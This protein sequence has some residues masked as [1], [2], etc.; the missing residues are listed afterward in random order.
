MKAAFVSTQ[1][2]STKA[3]ALS[4]ACLTDGT[5]LKMSHHWL[6]WSCGK[7]RDAFADGE[8]S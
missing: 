1:P 2:E 7:E 6:L 4:R 3:T 5:E 8:S